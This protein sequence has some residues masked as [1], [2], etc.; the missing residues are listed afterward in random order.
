MTTIR[1]VNEAGSTEREKNFTLNQ[2]IKSV[3][4]LFTAVAPVATGRLTLSSGVPV[5]TAT[6]TAA[7][8]IYYTPYNGSS[9]TELSQTLADTTKSP[10]AAV[11]SSNYDLFVW[12]D[13]KTTRLSRGPAWT[14]DTARGTGAGTSEL[15]ATSGVLGN[16]NAITNGPAAGLGVYVGTI[17]TDSGGATC[18][19]TLGTAAANGGAASFGVWNMYNRVN[20]GTIVSDTAAWA[21]A[22]GTWRAANG[23][24]TARCSFVSGLAEDDFAADYTITAL[25]STSNALAG[26]GFDSTSVRS[27]RAWFAFVA[28]AN[29]GVMGS[30]RTT[31][32][33]FHYFQA[34]E[35]LQTTAGT[36]TW[37][38]FALAGSDQSG[39]SVLLRM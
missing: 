9:F 25:P 2:L 13:N 11:A 28:G 39:L 22:V 30:Y 20:V 10:A 32:L 34:I 18:S 8:T 16:K 33:G 38:G 14:S 5:M 4:A 31:A 27:G 29:M 21:Y 37:Y 1:V 7:A 3:S 35:R 23:S 6:V 24:N 19:W 12:T 15:V 36:C 17:R 26:V